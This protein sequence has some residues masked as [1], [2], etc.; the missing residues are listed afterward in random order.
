MKQKASIVSSITGLL[1]PFI[2]VF[3][4]YV[5]LNGHDTPGGGFQGGAILAVL[6]IGRYIVAHTDDFNI[7]RAHNTEKALLV[8]LI[9]VPVVFVFGSLSRRFPQYNQVY[10]VFMN[11]LI[12]FKVALGLT[13]V[14]FRYA[15][16]ED[17]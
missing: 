15:F 12:G 10:L 13:V 8:V 14:V 4:I 2:I 7:G 17:R 16:Y 1:Y 5:I 11:L 3:G 9:L 6:F